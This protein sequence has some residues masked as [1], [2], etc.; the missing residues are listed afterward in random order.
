MHELVRWSMLRRIYSQRQLHE[1]MTEFWLNLLHIPAPADKVA[2][3]NRIGYDTLVRRHALGRYDELLYATTTSPSMG[4]YLDNAKSEAANPNENL[5]RELLELHTVG[6]L[7]GY[8]EADVLASARILTGWKVDLFD[9][10]QPY[11]DKSDHYTGPVSVLNFSDPNRN[12]DGRDLT[13]RYLRYL[14]H[15]PATARRIAHRLAV[16]FVSDDPPADLVNRVKNAYLS[17]GTDIEAT[18]RALVEHPEFDSAVGQKVRTPSEDLIATYRV[19]GVRATKPSG[20]TSDLSEAI[21]WQANSMGLQP[22]EWPTPDGPP[23]VNDAWTSVSRM[24]GS[25]Q[26]HRNLAGGWWPNTAADYRPKRSFL[27][28]LPARFDEIVDHVCRELHARPTTDELVAAACAAVGVRRWDR[29]TEDHWVVE[30]QVPNL[31]RALLDTP[32]HMS[33]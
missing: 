23:D 8:D 33:R 12:P 26:Q 17:S 2:W 15:H 19:L 1:V 16:R 3:V 25:W 24:L 31:L 10:W 27:P 30:W 6:R 9:T 7:G 21:I 14:A 13:R 22:F 11:Y 4:C 20:R 28:R 5:G 29:I 32:R 18:L